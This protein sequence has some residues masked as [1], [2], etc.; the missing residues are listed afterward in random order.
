MVVTRKES[1]NG[2]VMGHITPTAIA[3][4]MTA[5]QCSKS[6]RPAYRDR[7][8]TVA[9][10][11]Y[12][13]SS[14]AILGGVPSAARMSPTDPMYFFSL[15]EVYFL[16]AEA[17]HLT[18]NATQAK[19]NYDLAVKEAYAKF[20]LTMPPA[21]IAPGGAYEFPAAGTTAAKHEAIIVQK[22]VAMFRQGA[23][24]FWDQARTGYPKIS[25]VPTTSGSYVPGQWTLSKN[26]V[27]TGFPKRALYP[28]ATRDVNPNT[29]PRPVATNK[30][31]W[32]P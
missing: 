15:D 12:N 2:R 5:Q 31:W 23:E 21:V 24:S 18:G 16:L 6:A 22:W 27:T 14:T 13:A 30:I 11:D 29:P 25:P 32:M 4:A 26:A 1:T 19:A 8:D 10:G 17:Y 28:D 7:A 9:Q 3:A 20:G